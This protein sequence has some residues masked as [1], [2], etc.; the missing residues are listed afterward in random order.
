M[1]T[2]VLLRKAMGRRAWYVTHLG[3]YVLLPLAFVH[4]YPI[5]MTLQD[6]G[7]R[8]V[9]Q[10]LFVLTAAFYVL[11]LLA[12]LGVF[13][14]RYEVTA[15]RHAAEGVVEL[16]MRPIGRALRP[17]SGQFAFFRR[18][19]AGSGRPFTI[20]DSDDADGRLN[21]TVKALGRVTT[22]LQTV[23]PG[24]RFLVDGPYGTFGR[25]VLTTDRPV[26][27]LAGGIG[28]TP[29]RKLIRDL[30]R[31]PGREAY[32][33]YGNQYEKSIAHREEIEAAEHVDLIHVLS[34]VEEHE[35]FEVGLITIELL[36][37]HLEGALSRHE[38]LL[39]GPPVM[40]DK[41]EAGLHAE[42]VPGRQIHHEVF[43]Y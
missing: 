42:N 13:S 25:E 43:D 17:A 2:S 34:G 22:A 5:G 33:F 39:C 1:L 23:R 37:K 19:I 32:L 11:R 4:G 26:V 27:M 35:E 6:T 10:G 12:Q 38:F 16:V 24:E 30:E 3:S 31:Q 9:W 20:S 41:L 40:V 15:V 29:F 14:A 28:I 7:L 36:K 8:H 18:G 21:I